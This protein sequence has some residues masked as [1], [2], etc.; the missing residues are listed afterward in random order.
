MAIFLGTLVIVILCCLAM[1]M[2]LLLSGTPFRGGCGNK[3]AGSPR[4]EGCPKKDLHGTA[5]TDKEG[6]SR[7]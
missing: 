4:C 3:P 7:C 1:G 2:G 5:D 6:E